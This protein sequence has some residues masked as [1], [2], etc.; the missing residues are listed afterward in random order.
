[1]I[2]IVIF[3][4]WFSKSVLIDLN[5]CC[6]LVSLSFSFSALEQWYTRNASRIT[7]NVRSKIFEAPAALS[8]R[9]FIAIDKRARKEERSAAYALIDETFCKIALRL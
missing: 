2:H 8:N 4:Q 7:S 6:I 1:M 3:K 9:M 5:C